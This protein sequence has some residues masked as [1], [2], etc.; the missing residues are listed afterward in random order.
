MPEIELLD[1]DEIWTVTGP[2]II[3]AIILIFVAVI[4]LGI[5]SRIEKGLIKQIVGI[6]I[7]VGIVV[8]TYFSFQITSMI[9]GQ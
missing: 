1:F 6:G 8:V 2:F 3:T 7:I 4:S 5:L 9:W